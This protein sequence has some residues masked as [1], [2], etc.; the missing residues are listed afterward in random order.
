MIVAITNVYRAK[1]QPS[2]AYAFYKKMP[3]THTRRPT[4]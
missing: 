2:N 1:L 3:V 4:C